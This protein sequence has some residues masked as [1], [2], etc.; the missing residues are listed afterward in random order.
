MAQWHN[1]T[2]ASPS[3]FATQSFQTSNVMRMF[4]ETLKMDG[5]KQLL[6]YSK[7][8]RRRK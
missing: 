2:M 5:D 6:Y 3:L 4:I 1:G 7:A 8:I